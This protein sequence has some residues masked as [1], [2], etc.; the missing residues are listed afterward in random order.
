M[1]VLILEDSYL[2]NYG[3]W[4]LLI[5][6]YYPKGQGIVEQAHGTL[7]QYLHK[8]QERGNYIPVYYKII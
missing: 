8:K 4:M 6:P 1:V 5:F 3:K 2:I 7:K